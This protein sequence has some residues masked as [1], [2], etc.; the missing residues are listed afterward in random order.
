MSGH[1][2]WH[3]IKHKKALTDAKKS[4]NYG[5]VAKL[6]TIAAKA[7][8]DPNMNPALEQALQKAKYNSLPREVI[9]KAIKK[10][11]G[12]LEGEAYEEILYEGYG[13]NG[14]ALLIKALT[15]NK[16]KTNTTIKTLLPKRGGAM[17]EPWSVVRW[18][19]EVGSICIDGRTRK[20]IIKGNEVEFVDP[21]D[22]EEL[23]M[24]AMDLDVQDIEEEDGCCW[25]TTAK[26][27]FIKTT[28]ELEV[29]WYHVK[30]AELEYQATN[31]VSVDEE[32]GEKC[33]QLIE[34]LEEDDD[35]DSVW[36]N[37]E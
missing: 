19:A 2:K 3:N 13:P 36:D 1:S 28:K 10:G 30:E 5:K 33:V 37:M 9:D 4:K 24:C 21:Y 7:G 23:A 35:I 27:N 12:I 22:Q 32:T 29:K 17:G 11:A 16:N 6:I 25:L 34:S 26:E 31:K 15:S 14:V 20:E 8:A 18:F